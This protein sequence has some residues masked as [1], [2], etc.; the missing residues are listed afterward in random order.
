MRSLGYIVLAAAAL[1]ATTWI[2]TSSQRQPAAK[3]AGLAGIYERV[4][5]SV[6]SCDGNS[7][8]SALHSSGLVAVREDG[9]SLVGLSCP[10]PD[11]CQRLLENPDIGPIEE[12]GA[13]REPLGA[14][15]VE[16]PWRVRSH[17]D[18]AA[19]ATFVSTSSSPG[20]EAIG[21][22]A[23]EVGTVVSATEAGLQVDWSFARSGLIDSDDCMDA[24]RACRSQ[25]RIELARTSAP[26]P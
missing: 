3:P 24:S 20:P 5:A 19:R 21:C 10:D 11:A 16:M 14:R 8:E 13:W 9:S 12:P 15:W 23:F 4:S 1:A 7:G 26:R 22:T 17:T 25:I 2:A 6:G 18:G